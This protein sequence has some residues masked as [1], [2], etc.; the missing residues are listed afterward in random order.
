M[1]L[2]LC[3]AYLRVLVVSD[4]NPSG[5]II[6]GIILYIKDLIL[7]V[8]PVSH[9]VECNPPG[10]SI[11]QNLLPDVLEKLLACL[12]EVPGGVAVARSLSDVLLL[13]QL[14]KGLSENI[15]RID[16]KKL[17]ELTIKL[18]ELVKKMV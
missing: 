5:K 11:G 14:G 15:S 7:C 2:C 16:I 1:L 3:L 8:D 17:Q 10:L 13:Q 6:S 12:P 18:N 4:D 9:S